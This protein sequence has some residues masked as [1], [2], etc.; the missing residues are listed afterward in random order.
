MK[1]STLNFTIDGVGFAA[2][3]FM[4]TSGVLMRYLLPPGSGHG[5]VIWGMDRHEWGD[6][7][8]LLAVVFLAV[9]AAHLVLHWR[10][11]L[12]VVRGQPSEA[13]GARLAIGTA[14]LVA[15]TAVAV[16]PL[17]STPQSREVGAGGRSRHALEHD[18]QALRGS[19][20]LQEV[21]DQSGVPVAHVLRE[22]EL[23][24][25]TSPDAR[26]G[27]LRRAHGFEMHDVR[28]AIDAYGE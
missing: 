11:I 21:A 13:S 23:P 12:C 28:A 22:L 15:L 19:M 5:R 9:I 16:A 10:W 7:H 24:E 18:N 3:V 27:R 14:A 26:L 20:T 1:R 6:M 8:S 4:L 2:F 25:T 17:A